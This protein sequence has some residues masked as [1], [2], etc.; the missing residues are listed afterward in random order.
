[1]NRLNDM[2]PMLKSREAVIEE[3]MNNRRMKLWFEGLG[4]NERELFLDICTGARGMRITYD[5]YFKYVFD[6]EIHRDRL[7]DMLSCILNMKVKIKEV[8]PLESICVA[9]DTTLLSMDIIVE[10]EDGSIA[11]VEIQKIGYKFPGERAACYGADLLLRQS[12]RAKADRG[13]DRKFSYKDIKPVYTIIFY[14]KSPGEFK[15]KELEGIYKHYVS[16]VSNTPLKLNMLQN[17]YMISLDIFRRIYE[18][19]TVNTKEEAWLAFLSMDKPEQIVRLL[20]VFPEFK[21]IYT[22]VYSLASNTEKVMEMFSEE[23]RE[24]DEGTVQLMIDE[25]EETIKERG[26]IIKEQGEAIKKQDE[27]IKKQDEALKKQDE[28]LKKQDEALKKQD[29]ALKKQ[30]EAL[31]KLEEKCNKQNDALAAY[32]ERIRKLEEKLS[33]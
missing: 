9:S 1:M 25:Y 22:D 32:E 26:K 6:T 15:T 21:D 14:E 19:K 27:I 16:Y 11:N 20:E 30:D 29:E 28:A 31:K 18:N 4:E 24:L 12:K 5:V 13:E 2:F 23:L 3:I 17:Y 33:Q 8:L 7:E 10:F